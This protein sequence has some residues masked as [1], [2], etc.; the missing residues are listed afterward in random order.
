[1]QNRIAERL[2]CR[3][4]RPTGRSAS[5][6]GASDQGAPIGVRTL[7]QFNL[8]RSTIDVDD[9]DGL[10]VHDDNPAQRSA[11][12]D[13]GIPIILQRS[14]LDIGAWWRRGGRSAAVVDS[15]H[16]GC[17]GAWAMHRELR[18]DPYVGEGDDI[19]E[20]LSNQPEDD[21]DDTPNE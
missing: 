16:H 15:G 5:G 11:R 20:G 7:Q 6:G 12:L 1:M 21:D 2:P 17:H 18:E 3:A 4:P 14:P 8:D 13:Q 10:T 19:D 9:P